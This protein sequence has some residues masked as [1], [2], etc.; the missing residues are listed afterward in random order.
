MIKQS[1]FRPAFFLRNRHLQTILPNLVHPKHPKVD[2]ERLELDDGDFIDLDWSQTRSPQTLLI[3]HGLE[4][5]IKSSYAQRMLNYCNYHQIAAVFMHFRG[6]SGEQNRLLRSYHSGETGDLNQ[7]VEYLKNKGI[8]RIALLGYSIGGNQVMK[9]MGEAKTSSVI[10]CA[11]GISVPMT[12]SIC[13]STMN[14]GFAKIYQ[15]TLLGRLITKLKLKKTL[16]EHSELSFPDPE[17]MQNFQQFDD[18]F[19]APIH[20]FNSAH[21]YY[22]QSSS[23]QFLININK[24]SLIIQALDDPFMTTEVLPTAD[25]LSTSVTLEICRQGGHVGFISSTAVLPTSWLETR[26]HCFL[27]ESF[28]LKETIN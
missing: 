16:I 11:I 17:K 22:E 5:S 15:A 27:K 25:E 14:R 19:T 24:P 20:G 4:G 18:H 8:C 12:L 2:R 28:E 21:D 9:Y 10:C 3:L 1:T 6:C 23:R 26:I 7:V 13:S